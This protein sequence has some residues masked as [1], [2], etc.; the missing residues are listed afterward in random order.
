MLVAISCPANSAGTNVASGC[1][2]KT[3]YTGT[4]SASLIFPY[5]TGSCCAVQTGFDQDG[6][7]TEIARLDG[8]TS[9]QACWSLCVKNAKC[10]SWVRQPSTGTCWLSSTTPTSLIA[11]SDRNIGSLQCPCEFEPRKL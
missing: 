10:V 9:D 7:F 11:T 1:T 8:A 3:G 4:I 5:Y 2:C 6:G